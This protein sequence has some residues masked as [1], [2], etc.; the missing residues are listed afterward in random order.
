[1]N[2][3]MASS[4]MVPFAKT[5]GLA[6]VVGTLPYALQKLDCKVSVIIPYYLMV[7][8]SSIPVKMQFEGIP[9]ELGNEKFV[10]NILKATDIPDIEVYFVQQ[11]QFFGREDLYGT[12]HGDFEDNAKRFIFFNKMAL[13]FCE[14]MKYEPDIFHCHDWQTGLIPAYVKEFQ[15]A[16]KRFQKT[17]SIYTIHN[18]AY[19]GLFDTYFFYL[20][21]LPPSVYSVNGLEYWGKINLMKAGINFSDFITT[22]SKK[23]SDEIKTEEYG[24]GIDGILRNRADRLTGILNGVDYSV[25]NPDT[26]PLIAANYNSRSLAGK[27]QCKADLLAEFKLPKARKNK[28]LLGIISRLA[29]QKGFDLLAEIIDTLMQRDLSLVLLGTGEKKYHDLFREIARCYPEKAGIRIAYDNTLAHKI[30]AGSDMF[31]MPSRY[32]PCGLNQIYSL[33]Y[34]TVPVVRATGGLDDTVQAFQPG[35][36]QGNG[37]KF[38]DYSASAFLECIDAALSLYSDK[39]S[40]R[41]IVRNAMKADFSWERSAKEFMQLYQRAL[42]SL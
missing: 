40:W 21:G 18:I 31:L 2:I 33:K 29:D 35:T 22:V 39:K 11:Q 42:D 16:Q 13:T 3:L 4:E 1:M 10:G 9:V 19:Q 20:T 8:K 28:P 17:A 24:Y 32:E 36:G 27:K 23:Y 34:G 26:D 25:W 37:F 5:G 14:L 12:E 15:Q 38:Y 7:E 30:E 6:D 41:K